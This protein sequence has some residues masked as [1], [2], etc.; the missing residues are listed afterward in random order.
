MNFV[1]SKLSK[2][3]KTSFEILQNVAFLFRHA[4]IS[5]DH[6]ISNIPSFVG[7]LLGWISDGYKMTNLLFKDSNRLSCLRRNLVFC[8]QKRASPNEIVE[9]WEDCDFLIWLR[10]VND[11]KFSQTADV[12]KKSGKLPQ[13]FKISELD[14]STLHGF[15]LTR[16]QIRFAKFKI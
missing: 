8:S 3:L 1:E 9:S 16:K 13:V 4:R 15:G 10:H 5:I 6:M 11:G 12:I 2:Y 14:R 7:W